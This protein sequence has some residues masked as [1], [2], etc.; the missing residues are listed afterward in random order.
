MDLLNRLVSNPLG[1]FSVLAV[2]AI[3]EAW[4]DS[5][6]Q[7]SFYRTSG[8]ARLLAFA[9]GVVMLAVYGSLVNVP[10]WH[11]GRLIGLYVVPFFLVAQVVARLRFG[12]SPTPA[13]YVGGALIAAGGLVIAIWK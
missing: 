9:A 10:R 7:S 8:A 4:A 13:I 3:L 11:F 5:F 1:A 6:F 12:Q 2:A